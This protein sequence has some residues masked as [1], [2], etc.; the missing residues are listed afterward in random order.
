MRDGGYSALIH[1]SILSVLLLL[2]SGTSGIPDGIHAEAL[3]DPASPE[4][5]TA[6][7]AVFQALFEPT[8]YH[9][10]YATYL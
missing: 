8:T 2:L 4:M 6:A 1:L 7:P 10:V 3:K 9:H 5:N